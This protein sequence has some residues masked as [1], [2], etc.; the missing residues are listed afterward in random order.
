MGLNIFFKKLESKNHWF[1][2]LKKKIRIERMAA[3]G[4]FQEHQKKKKLSGFVKEPAR[5]RR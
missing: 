5:N 2:F 4:Y 1:W 3:S